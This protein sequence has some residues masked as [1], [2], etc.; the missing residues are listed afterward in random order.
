MQLKTGFLHVWPFQVS[1]VIRVENCH[2]FFKQLEFPVVESK[3]F[4]I[5]FESAC[6]NK[7]LGNNGINI[8]EFL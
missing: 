8:R 2:N 5:S 6:Y 7:S 4:Y 3:M 1:Y